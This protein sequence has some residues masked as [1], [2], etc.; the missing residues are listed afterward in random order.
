MITVLTVLLIVACLVTLGLHI[1]DIYLLRRKRIEESASPDYSNGDLESSAD[2]SSPASSSA[3]EMETRELIGDKRYEEMSRHVS[4][5]LERHKKD[6]FKSVMLT[7]GSIERNAIR[8]LH[9]LLP[10]DPV[11][12]QDNSRNGIPDVGVYVGD[13]RVGRLLLDDATE[14]LKA[15]TGTLVTG[16]YVAEQN[17]YG[18]NSN[19][20]S[21]KIIIFYTSAAIPDR[22]ATDPLKTPY[23]IIYRGLRP[24]VIYQ[25]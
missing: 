9:S 24:I 19:S 3:E 21:V 4:E 11:R 10:G 17:S 15:M 22:Q 6:T 2:I 14:A 20:I 12:L 8:T 16:A 5:L 23:K 7:A 13:E 1:Q 18:E 25:N